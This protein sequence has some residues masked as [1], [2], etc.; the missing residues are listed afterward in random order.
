MVVF[1]NGQSKKSDYRQ[2]DIRSIEK[3]DI[4]DFASMTEALQRR[5]KYISK[6]DSSYR[7]KFR[8]NITE[9]IK[10]KQVIGNIEFIKIND[11]TIE[12]STFNTSLS[13]LEL[14]T[15]IHKTI[16]KYKLKKIYYKK[17]L[18][19]TLKELGFKEI[20]SE[21][22]HALYAHSIS[23]D[24]SFNK[25]P[26]LIVIDGGK[27]QLSSALKAQKNL[28][29]KVEFI[30]I[31]KRLEEIFKEDKTRILLPENS[32]TLQLIQRLRNEAHRFAITNNR[33][34]RLKEYL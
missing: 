22:K 9:L 7:C 26:D 29:T 23:K 17:E 2:F 31:A 5:L 20:R 16:E 15:L 19:N 24:K 30:S 3:G 27:G 6:I 25:V 32:K 18:D 14:K 21:Y 12:L 1:E 28:N 4:N 10:D 11:T 8:E 13:F 33:K 34:K